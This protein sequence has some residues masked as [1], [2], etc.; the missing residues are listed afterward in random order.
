[1]E[2]TPAAARVEALILALDVLASG[3]SCSAGIPT[4]SRSRRSSAPPTW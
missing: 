3:S 4:E 1:M 2:N